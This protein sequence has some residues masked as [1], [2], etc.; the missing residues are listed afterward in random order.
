MCDEY[1]SYLPICGISPVLFWGVLGALVVGAL[2]IAVW[3]E[4]RRQK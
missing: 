2:A 3:S 1:N 4:V